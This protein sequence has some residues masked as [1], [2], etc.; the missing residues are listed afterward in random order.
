[1][2]TAKLIGKID[3]T[4]LSVLA[5][6][7]NI[8]DGGICNPAAYFGTTFHLLSSTIGIVANN[9]LGSNTSNATAVFKQLRSTLGDA[10]V[11][12]TNFQQATDA[13]RAALDTFNNWF[14]DQEYGYINL[15]DLYERLLLLEFSIENNTVVSNAENQ[16]LNSIGSFY[17]PTPLAD[18][19]VELTLDNYI[20]KNTG[21]ERFSA[22]DKT[23]AQVAVVTDLLL[24]S[25][26]ADHSCGTG[27]FLL[28]I[29]RYCK[30]HLPALAQKQLQ[31]L[32]LNFSAIEADAIA[33]EIAKI[34]VLEAV[35]GLE[36]YA[37]VSKNFIHGN[38]L[39]LPD[40]TAIKGEFYHEFYYHNGLALEP[41]Q[42][43]TCDVIVGNPPWGTATFD[44]PFFLHATFPQLMEIEDENEMDAALESLEDSHPA[45]YHWL[46]MHDEANDLCMENIY[47]DER[48]EHS[49]LGGLQ[50]NP[51][52]TELA[53]QLRTDRG[54]VGLLLKGSTLSNT[55]NKRLVQHLSERNRITARYDFIN[56]NR[57]FNLAEDETFS[58]LILGNSHTAEAIHQTGLTQLGEIA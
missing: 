5:K 25:T 38:P 1:M 16:E 6:N 39:I 21:I 49:M 20:G 29:L 31:Q 19:I 13:E 44:L 36:L 50:T 24:H 11:F 55:Q 42:I 53:D 17:T 2:A 9:N 54:T 26:F 57:I 35:N 8:K 14:Q 40:A 15:S 4:I 37:Q 45:L 43:A 23:P 30:K 34:Q 3:E 10:C 12:T 52:F 46:L 41:H 32:V 58:I 33:L 47:N 18:K 28:A 22:S 48:F 56:T 51:L 7:T 27:S